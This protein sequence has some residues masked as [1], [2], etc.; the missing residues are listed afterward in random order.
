M[1]M[2]LPVVAVRGGATGPR[3]LAAATAAAARAATAALAARVDEEEGLRVAEDADG[4]VPQ[5]E[6]AVDGDER[7]LF[8]GVFVFCGLV[9]GCVYGLQLVYM[10]M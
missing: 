6:L 7:L 9:G 1:P 8:R 4:R 5:P 3:P 2:L 10:Y